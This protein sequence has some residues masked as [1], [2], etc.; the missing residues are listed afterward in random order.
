MPKI[1]RAKGIGAV[2]RKQKSRSPQA[3]VVD[4]Q[5]T[6]KKTHASGDKAGLRKWLKAP[7]RSDVSGVDT[8]GKGK[9]RASK[10]GVKKGQCLK[11]SKPNWDGTRRCLKRA[12]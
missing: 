12:K 9:P 2:R 8:K 6:A 3:R 10:R 11:W 5:K 4:A 1:R 7:G